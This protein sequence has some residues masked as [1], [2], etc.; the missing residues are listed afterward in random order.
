VFSISTIRRDKANQA[1][2]I[3]DT[4][5]VSNWSCTWPYGH[6]RKIECPHKDSSSTWKN[7][8]FPTSLPVGDYTAH[9]G[10][11][12]FKAFYY[13][14]EF[15]KPWTRQNNFQSLKKLQ[16]LSLQD[17]GLKNKVH[18]SRSSSLYIGDVQ[19]QPVIRGVNWQIQYKSRACS[20][21][22]SPS[23]ARSLN[24]EWILSCCLNPWIASY[25]SANIAMLHPTPM[26]QE[27]RKKTT[28]T[29]LKETIR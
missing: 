29:D 21:S 20:L 24:R 25:H 6:V 1:R 16:T 8:I 4:S 15:T 23:K 3:L 22:S 10:R 28:Y 12:Y 2:C 17:Q 18:E 5:H 11:I 14:R 9:E 27:E 26:C 13:E 19:R 7:K